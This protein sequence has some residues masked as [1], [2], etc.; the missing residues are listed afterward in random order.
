MST[1]TREKPR[2]SPTLSTPLRVGPFSWLVPMRAG[3]VVVGALLVLAALVALD[4]SMGDFQIPVADVV[5]TLL[6]G[7]DPGQRFIVTEL[8]LPQTLVAILVGAAL[9]LAGALTQTF[10]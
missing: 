10:A 6:G 2:Y 3:L 9:G 4:L 5:R 8:R 7:G 1:L